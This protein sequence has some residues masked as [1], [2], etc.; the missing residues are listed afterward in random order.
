VEAGAVLQGV[1]GQV[2]DGGKNLLCYVLVVAMLVQSLW[3]ATNINREPY[4][5]NLTRS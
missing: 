3:L 4:N 5:K 2:S 1:A